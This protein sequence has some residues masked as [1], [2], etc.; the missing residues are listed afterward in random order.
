MWIYNSQKNR[1]LEFDLSDFLF[2]S[3]E[4]VAMYFCICVPL[5][6]GTEISIKGHS[7]E[8]DQ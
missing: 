2:L 6:S 5:H 8:I 7:I 3:I 1:T 4:A